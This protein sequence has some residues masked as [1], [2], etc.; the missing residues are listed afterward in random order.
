MAKPR[1]KQAFEM[2]LVVRAAFWLALGAGAVLLALHVGNARSTVRQRIPANPV[3]AFQDLG[4]RRLHWPDGATATLI[5]EI[6]VLLLLLLV[7]TAAR[8][9]VTR[10]RLAVDQKARLMARGKAIVPFTEAGSR[11][12]AEQLGIRLGDGDSPGI[13]IGTAVAGGKRLFGSYDDLHLDIWGPRQGKTSCRSIPAIVE[14][15]GPVIATSSKRDVLDLTRKVRMAKGSR[16]FVFDPEGIA[17]EEPDWFWDPL[18]WV[19]ARYEG[20]EIRAARLAGHFADST[21]SDSANEMERFYED[22]AEDLL[23]GLFLAAAVGERPII[24]VWEWVLSP[25][26]TEPIELL[27]VARHHWSASALSA[28]YS[29]GRQQGDRVFRT[30]RRMIGCLALA[31]VHAWIT[32]GGD[33]RQ[34]DELEF[35][36]T[37]GTLYNLSLEGRGSAAP[38]VS[39]LIEAVLDVAVRKASLCPGGRLPTPLLAVLDDATHMVRWRDFPQR[40]SHYGSHGII[41]MTM[42]QSWAQGVRCWG[43][44]GMAELWSA[45]TIKVLG[46]GVDEAPFLRDRMDGVGSHDVEIRSVTLS[47]SGLGYS[48]TI[49]SASTLGVSDLRSL[50]RTRAVMFAPG[51]PPVLIKTQPWWEGEYATAVRRSIEDRATQRRAMATD[52]VGTSGLVGLTSSGSTEP[53]ESPE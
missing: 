42:L 17:K 26:D 11:A 49:S 46:G 6:V 9:W 32:P 33:R 10:G 50:P 53:M 25:F 41:L 40:Y 30:A 12:R 21:R 5:V 52:L 16:V 47:T 44:N 18:A 7:F 8:R 20:C 31:A 27:R 28:Q 22:E 39:A 4:R 1:R 29:T 35:I 43:H 36:E 34:F 2:A 13:P 23:K 51:I 3:T 14:A 48:T 19:D 38:L 24:Q 45:A 37:N 15:P